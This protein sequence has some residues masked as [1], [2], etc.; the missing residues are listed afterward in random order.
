MSKIKDA[1][2]SPI[3][4][5]KDQ[6]KTFTDWD[7]HF[8]KGG[9]VSGLKKDLDIKDQIINKKYRKE[10]FEDATNRLK[11]GEADLKDSYDYHKNMFKLWFS[12]GVL[13]ALIIVTIIFHRNF[14]V[15]LPASAFMIVSF[16]FCYRASYHCYCINH[17]VL[18]GLSKWKSSGEWFPRPF[19]F[20]D[21]N[22][23]MISRDRKLNHG[24]SESSK[25]SND[26]SSSKNGSNQK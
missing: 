4:W 2:F 5:G 14:V 8:G 7:Y 10:T 15:C 6:A 1:I 22:Q 18:S 3:K 11:M 13:A 9:T 21:K 23:A 24:K 26:K 17:R 20:K 25:S 12:L 16:G 19:V